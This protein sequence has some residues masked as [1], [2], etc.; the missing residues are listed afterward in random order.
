MDVKV[1]KERVFQ[2]TKSSMT[3]AYTQASLFQDRH[4]YTVEQVTSDKRYR[5]MEMLK[6]KGVLHK[7]YA[8][9]LIRKIHHDGATGQRHRNMLVSKIDCL[10]IQ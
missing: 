2:P 9:D 4:G 8:R 3:E 1:D 5:V 7:P 10:A 6:F